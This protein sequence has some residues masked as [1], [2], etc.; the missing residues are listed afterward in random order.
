MPEIMTHR[1][2]QSIAELANNA[3]WH[4]EAIDWIQSINARCTQFGNIP[5]SYKER[6]PSIYTNGQN[7]SRVARISGFGKEHVS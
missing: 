1:S 5:H 3:R 4:R 2:L 7:L 6:P